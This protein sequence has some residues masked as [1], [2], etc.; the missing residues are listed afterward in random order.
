MLPTNPSNASQGLPVQV[1]PERPKTVNSGAEKDGPRFSDALDGQ[2]KKASA[3][4]KEAHAE[5]GK[6]SPTAKKDE[7]GGETKAAASSD[8]R[9]EPEDG[10]PAAPPKAAAKEETD[11]PE[12]GKTLPPVWTPD[13]FVTET[14]QPVAAVQGE[15]G[16]EGGVLP[17]ALPVDEAPQEVAIAADPTAPLAAPAII[18]GDGKT[19]PTPT[20]LDADGSAPV[21][22]EG[23][24]AV[25]TAS[26]LLRNPIAR[27]GDAE[28]PQTGGRGE[29]APGSAANPV[30]L[31]SQVGG[32]AGAESVVAKAAS[33]SLELLT[34]RD[35]PLAGKGMAI[36]LQSAQGGAAPASGAQPAPAAAQPPAALPTAL[37]LSVPVRQAGWDQALGERVVWMTKEGVQ[38]A[39]VQ[40]HPRHLGPI[41]VRISVHQDQAS[42]AFTAHNPVTRDALEAAMPRLR[43]MMGD[44]GLNLVQSDVSQQSSQQQRQALGERGGEQRGGPGTPA[45]ALDGPEASPVGGTAVI[46]GAVD[47]FA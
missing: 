8:T 23:D 17:E 14:P 31:V 29:P 25:P 24:G 4:R 40:L 36:E 18:P 1:Q 35:G 46:S 41:E 45:Q 44:N 22:G 43:E 2:M 26:V 12:S 30:P 15:L 16:D 33:Q 7:K 19:A 37:T 3:R 38:E 47:Y 28:Q 32:N 11:V 27:G 9:A 5:P 42:V 20:A 21:Q 34:E 39:T 13:L 10:A 6:P